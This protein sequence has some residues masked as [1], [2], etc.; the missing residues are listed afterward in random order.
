MNL[1]FA[2]KSIRKKM[3]ITQSELCG[4]CHLSQTSLS[5]IET[6]VKHPSQKTITRICLKL[7]IPELVLYI[8]AMQE[9]DVPPAKR[10]IYDAIYPSIYRLTLQLID[11]KHADI[12]EEMI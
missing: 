8:L 1:G 7:E 11:Q 4:L 3:R 5:Q 6:G 12:M 9:T 2:I 10:R